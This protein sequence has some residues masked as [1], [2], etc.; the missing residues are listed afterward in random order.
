MKRSVDGD[1][2]CRH[3]TVS[4]GTVPIDTAEKSNDPDLCIKGPKTADFFKVSE[5]RTRT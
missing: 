5:I 3:R 1:S 4:E 2:S